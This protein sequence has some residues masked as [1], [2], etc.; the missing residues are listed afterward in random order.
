VSRQAW[1]VIEGICDAP[2]AGIRWSQ[3][4]RLIRTGSGPEDATD[5]GQQAT[6]AAPRPGAGQ[7]PDRLLHQRAQAGLVAVVGAL[8]VGQPI[9]GPP[10]PDLGMPVL[11]GRG[12]PAKAPINQGD[13]PRDVKHLNDPDNARGSCSWQLPGQ[14]PSP[15]SRSPWIVDTTTPWAL[16]HRASR[17]PSIEVGKLLGKFGFW[18]APP[19]VA[20][21]C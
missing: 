18:F 19:S 8:S 10:V 7:L 11:A 1:H 4:P 17:T 16:A 13:G 6:P 14:P 12:Q 15:H 5:P 9:L 21:P 20:S 3:R 2:Q